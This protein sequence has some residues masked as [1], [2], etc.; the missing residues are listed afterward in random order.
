MLDL[1][2]AALMSA[3]DP[4]V[5]AQAPSA[6]A[7]VSSQ[8]SAAGKPQGY[9]KV[10]T[11]C[12]DVQNLEPDSANNDFGPFHEELYK[13]WGKIPGEVLTPEWMAKVNLKVTV[14]EAPKHG[15]I[16]A[17]D[18][19]TYFYTFIPDKDYLGED[20]LVYEIEAQGKRYKQTINFWVMP[21]VV[22]PKGDDPYVP[23]CLYQKFNGSALDPA[24]RVGERGR[25]G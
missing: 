12:Q 3:A 19:A 2:V 10:F 8:S 9:E 18:A 13:R 4:I 16:K 11:G 14:L 20:R 1:F 7:A 25:L 5:V 24:T 22:D 21:V 15:K 6:P 17:I 23:D